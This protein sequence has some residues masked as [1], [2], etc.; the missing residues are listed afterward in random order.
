MSIYSFDP[1]LLSTVDN[2]FVFDNVG[3]PAIVALRAAPPNV[4]AACVRPILERVN[5]LQELEKHENQ[6]WNG[7][8]VIKSAIQVWFRENAKWKRDHERNPRAPRWPSLY[9]YDSLGRPHRAGPGSDSGRVRTYFG[10]TGKRIPFAV[11]LLPDTEGEWLAPGFTEASADPHLFE[12]G[13]LNRL[14]CRVPI[15]DEQSGGTRP[16]G[17]TESWKAESRSSRAA[18]RARM[19]KHLRRATES[20]DAH[21]ELHTNEFGSSTEAS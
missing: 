7:I 19:S 18:A 13:N 4:T 10:P 9:S 12:D 20:V 2:Q 3:K 5:E 16:C 6:K 1:V 17:H 15:R 11:S 14:E 21:R 8:E